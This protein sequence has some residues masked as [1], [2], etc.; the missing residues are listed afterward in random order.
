VA[1]PA[2]HLAAFLAPNK[3]VNKGK[4][5]QTPSLAV[6]QDHPVHPD[7][8]NHPDHPD[9]RDDH[10][11]PLLSVHPVRR[12]QPERLELM[13][14]MTPTD[15][16]HLT[17][18]AEDAKS[19]HAFYYAGP[20]RR[21]GSVEFDLTAHYRGPN[22]HQL[23]LVGYRWRPGMEMDRSNKENGRKTGQFIYL[24]KIILN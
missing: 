24:F 19:S 5:K 1:V 4:V 12:D 14:L 13:L 17:A 22:H 20:R 18:N 16:P 9:Y 2:E 15:V 6:D 8:P 7:H 11:H 10:D 21:D 3:S 23:T